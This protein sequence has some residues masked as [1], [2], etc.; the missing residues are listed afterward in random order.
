MAA[1]TTG[2]SALRMAATPLT[3]VMSTATATPTTTTLPTRMAWPSGSAKP[4]RCGRSDG[5][6]GDGETRTFAEGELIPGQKAKT[7]LRCSQPDAAHHKLHIIR[8]AASGKANSFRCSSLSQRTRY[9]GLRREKD[10]GCGDE[11]TCTRCNLHGG[12]TCEYPV[13]WLVLLRR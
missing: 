7:I 4:A 6:T 12:R 5:V 13:S 9:A 8:L 3:S 11:M 1:R 2:G 10:A